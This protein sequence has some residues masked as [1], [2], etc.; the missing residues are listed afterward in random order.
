MAAILP[1][2]N[3]D[4]L[5][6]LQYL[7][8]RTVD[9]KLVRQFLQKPGLFFKPTLFGLIP[10]ACFFAVDISCRH[11]WY[12]LMFWFKIKS[13]EVHATKVSALFQIN[14]EALLSL[15][16]IY[17]YQSM[18]MP[19]LKPLHISQN[20]STKCSIIGLKIYVWS[21]NLRVYPQKS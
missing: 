10:H 13:T 2:W 12:R 7:H 9:F 6:F 14:Y 3:R 1:F 20:S 4:D 11:W 5:F 15:L 21:V 8:Y 19:F 16:Y 18:K 17:F